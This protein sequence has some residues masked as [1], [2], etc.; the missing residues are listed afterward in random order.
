VL[1]A[2]TDTDEVAEDEL[3]DEVD[4]WLDV[5]LGTLDVLRTDEVED[6]LDVLGVLDV[7]RIDDVLLGTLE[8]LLTD[9]EVDPWLEVLMTDD[10]D[11]WIDALLEDVL[12]VATDAEEVVEEEVD[13]WLEVLLAVDVVDP[14][15]V[16]LVAEVDA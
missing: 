7:L 1:G 5:L 2:N 3:E 10:V 8:V 11:T 6:W 12:G 13:P 15:L 9:E 14:R 4:P 16:L